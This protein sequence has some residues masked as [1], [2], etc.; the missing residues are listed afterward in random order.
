MLIV[1]RYYD[2]ELDSLD[3]KL[4]AGKNKG[5]L[6]RTNFYTFM[7]GAI[8]DWWLD[9]HSGL[10]KSSPSSTVKYKKEWACFLL[11]S[12]LFRCNEFNEQLHKSS[13]RRLVHE[14]IS[15]LIAASDLISTGYSNDEKSELNGIAYLLTL[16]LP[17]KNI[18]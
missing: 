3:A 17:G 9:Y 1:L 7:H 10:L 14:Q 18:F 13:T 6:I 4:V 2:P 15:Y 12:R 8:H 16:F 5:R 11:G